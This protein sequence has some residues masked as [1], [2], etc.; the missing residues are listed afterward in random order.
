MHNGTALDVWCVILT[1]PLA[2]MFLYYSIQHQK[3]PCF[4]AIQQAVLVGQI[5]SREFSWSYRSMHQ[6]AIGEDNSLKETT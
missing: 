5:R 1:A 3:Q 4:K 6:T 2:L